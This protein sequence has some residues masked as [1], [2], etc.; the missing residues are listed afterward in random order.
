M[1]KKIIAKGPAS[2]ACD[3][4]RDGPEMWKSRDVSRYVAP[5]TEHPGSSEPYSHKPA[6]NFSPESFGMLNN[7][8]PC[9]QVIQLCF[10]FWNS[11][12]IVLFGS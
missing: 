6:T 5:Q 3:Q 12:E 9:Q 1:V 2:T 11:N 10:Q 7:E 8:S 4:N